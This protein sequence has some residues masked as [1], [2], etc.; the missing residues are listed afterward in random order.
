MRRMLFV[1]T[2]ALVMV[3]IVVAM[4]AP[5]FAQAQGPRGHFDNSCT[6]LGEAFDHTLRVGHLL[7]SFNCL[8]S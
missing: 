3:V 6:G 4:A 1:L 7:F 8:N 2:V 5:A